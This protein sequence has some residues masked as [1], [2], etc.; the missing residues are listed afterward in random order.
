MGSEMCIRDR[1]F[2]RGLYQLQDENYKEALNIFSEFTTD[3]PHHQKRPEALE[4]IR[5]INDRLA[6]KRRLIGC[7]LPLT[8]PYAAFGNRALKGIQLALDQF[9]SQSNQPAFEIIVKDTR[10]DPK[11]T[12]NAIRQFDKSRVSIIIG[13]IITSE[14]AAKEA[15]IRGIPII[16][17]SQKPDI[18]ELGDYVFRVFLTPQMQMDTLVP[19]VVNELGIKRFAVLYPEENYGNIFFKIFRERVLDH[20]GS[21]VAVASYRP[22]QTDF[23][24]QI[25]KI[26]KKRTPRQEAVPISENHVINRE[27]RHQKYEVILDFDAIFIPDSADKIALIAPQLAFYDIDNVLLMG[28]NLWH[29]DKLINLAQNY[30][31]E[32]I[33]TDAFYAKDSK[34]NIKKFITDFKRINGESPG[35]IEALAYDTAMVNFYNLSNPKIQ[36]RSDLKHALKKQPGFDGVTGRTSFKENGD[37]VKRLYLLQ[38]EEN[39]FVQVN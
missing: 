8:G 26:L 17:L 14:Y 35:L 11:T 30:V 16:T 34:K 6:F 1:L 21:L 22:E 36:S 38:V 23:A 20:G 4:L 15:Q 10:S 13:S 18:P 19:Y 5:K 31:Q 37:A 3:F 25:K 28:T 33:L 27:R 24:A 29:S 9:N 7:L 39:R 12:I 2:E 32:A